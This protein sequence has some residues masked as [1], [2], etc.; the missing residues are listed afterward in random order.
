MYKQIVNLNKAK[1]SIK[2]SYAA[3]QGRALN[4]SGI[5]VWWNGNEIFD[6]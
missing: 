2:F 4:S 3:R 5:R 1:F 6:L